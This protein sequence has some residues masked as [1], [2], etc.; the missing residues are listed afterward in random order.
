M[1]KRE[2]ARITRWRAIGLGLLALSILVA[3]LA[4]RHS[5]HR[6]ALQLAHLHPAA[7]LAGLL[8]V[9][10]GVVNR[11]AHA[12]AAYRLMALPARLVP[13][14]ELTAAS[15]ATNKL[16]KSAGVAG[17]VPFLTDARVQGHDRDRVISAYLCMSAAAS[18]AQAL[19]VLVA[20]GIS[21]AT[22]MLDGAARLGAAAAVAYSAATV[23][24]LVVVAGNGPLVR[25]IVSRATVAA[26]RAR[27]TF[28]RARHGPCRTDAGCIGTAVLAVR[29]QPLVVVRLVA[30]AL[31]GKLIGACTLAAVLTG[32][33]VR[34]P[35]GTILVVYTLTLVASAA[36]P[37]P[38]GIGA[39][40]ASL[41]ALLVG[42]GVGAETA[43]AAVVAFRL[44]DVWVPIALVPIGRLARSYRSTSRTAG[45]SLPLP[46][47][48]VAV[49]GS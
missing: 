4:N 25:S 29:H 18:L 2:L 13:M 39:A 16:V 26:Y 34:L 44:L 35:V 32:L 8:A 11:G 49:A 14:V 7:L 17:I 33:G 1:E 9:G 41:G 12:Q 6:G 15:Y 43:A 24:S 45:R 3:T 28:G 21:F 36:G 47:P 46:L 10:L 20:V 37:L 31:T 19:V 27:A 42:T 30:T 23:G 5:V 22:G 40:E 38:A 48:A